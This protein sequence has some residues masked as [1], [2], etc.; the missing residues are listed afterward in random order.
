MS[1]VTVTTTDGF[2]GR[3][4]TEYRGVV[5][6]EA[7]SR[8]EAWV[9]A[10]GGDP[11]VARDATGLAI[12]GIDPEGAAAEKRLPHWFGEALVLVLERFGYETQI[13]GDML[14]ASCMRMPASETAR[15]LHALGLVLAVTRLMDV[16]LADAADARNE[17]SLFLRRFF[18][19]DAS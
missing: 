3:E 10:Q 13:K 19:E 8:F 5:S 16:K 14:D 7:I 4:I 1:D 18:P 6:G 17:A 11:A 12:T 2:E 15:A 9:A